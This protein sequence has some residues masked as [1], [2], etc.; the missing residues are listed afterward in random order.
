MKQKFKKEFAKRVF[1]QFHMILIL[2]GTMLSGVIFS[3]IL[4]VLGRKHI[5]ARFIIVLGGGCDLHRIQQALS[6]SGGDY[7]S[8]FKKNRGLVLWQQ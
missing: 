5:I 3:K 8:I 4:L 1:T 2:L 6:I 7:G